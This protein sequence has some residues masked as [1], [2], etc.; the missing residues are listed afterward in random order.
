MSADLATIDETPLALTPA[1]RAIEGRSTNGTAVQIIGHTWY[2]A[3]YPPALTERWDRLFDENVLRGEYDGVDVWACAAELLIENYLLTYD[4]CCALIM[5]Q[6]P[7][8]YREAVENALFG[9]RPEHRT[10]SQWVESVLWGVGQNP[11]TISPKARRLA[12]DAIEAAGL[13]VSTAEFI[14]S[15]NFVAR[16]GRSGEPANG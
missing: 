13:G 16:K 8:A 9:T 14:S 6:L 15:V 11:D 3:A 2:L 4:E 7:I 10:Y 12:V 1:D 5:T